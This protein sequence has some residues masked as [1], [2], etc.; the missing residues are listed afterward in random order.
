MSLGELTAA[1]KDLVAALASALQDEDA[2]VRETAAAALAALG[3][4]AKDAVPALAAALKEQPAD[5]ENFYTPEF[6]DQLLVRY[7]R[8]GKWSKPFAVW[9]TA[10]MADVAP[11][12]LL[13][14]SVCGAETVT[15]G[16]SNGT[17]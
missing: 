10:G 17:T 4:R 1:D 12:W 8:S 5:F 2:V 14:P 13:L 9:P 7:Y 3:S 6:R 16:A 15:C 11:A